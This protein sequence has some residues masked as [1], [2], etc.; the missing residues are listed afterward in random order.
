MYLGIRFANILLILTLSKTVLGEIRDSLDLGDPDIERTSS[1]ETE[2]AATPPRGQGCKK[3][4]PR[5]NP[6]DPLY[7]E[8]VKA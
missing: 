6:K 2:E 5:I 4:Y 7:F 1:A 8:Q 3:E